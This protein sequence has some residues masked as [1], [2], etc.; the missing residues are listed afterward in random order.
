M[1]VDNVW[2]SWDGDKPPYYCPHCESEKEPRIPDIKVPEGTGYQ[3]WE[4]TSE[5]SP[6]S[7]VFE[8]AEA[9]AKWLA[10]NGASSFGDM[11]ATYAQW[12]AMIVGNGFACSA[13]I[14]S[15]GIKSGAEAGT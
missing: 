2:K 12:H 11:T 7:P 6:I 3:M 15:D 13:M 10:D 14:S 9:L 5:G 8:T 1:G 4:T